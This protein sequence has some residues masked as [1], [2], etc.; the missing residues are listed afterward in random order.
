VSYILSF[1]KRPA[2]SDRPVHFFG[3]WMI[4]WTIDLVHLPP[5][6]SPVSL[7]LSPCPTE[8]E[9]LLARLSRFCVLHQDRNI[10]ALRHDR[11]ILKPAAITLHNCVRLVPL[12]FTKVPPTTDLRQCYHSWIHRSRI[13]PA[14]PVQHFATSSASLARFCCQYSFRTFAVSSTTSIGG[15]CPPDGYARSCCVFRFPNLTNKF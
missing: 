7:L 15:P 8:R 2:F 9:S 11:R 10:P 3:Q 13:A 14:S 6:S 5:R 1:Q 12:S 4:S